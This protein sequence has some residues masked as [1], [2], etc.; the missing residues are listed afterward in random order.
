MPQILAR[1]EVLK[2]A[3][4]NLNLTSALVA[5][6]G[7]PTIR[8]NSHVGQHVPNARRP[9]T[10]M[11]RRRTKKHARD[12]PIPVRSTS[13]KLPRPTRVVHGKFCPLVNGPNNFTRAGFAVT[14]HVRIIQAYHGVVLRI[15]FRRHKVKVL[16]C[17]DFLSKLSLAGFLVKHCARHHEHIAMKTAHARN[18]PHHAVKIFSNALERFV[19]NL[20]RILH[21]PIARAVSPLH[22]DFVKHVVHYVIMCLDPMQ[23]LHAFKR[24]RVV[25]TRESTRHNVRKEA[26]VNFIDDTRAP[27][28]GSEGVAQFVRRRRFVH[29]VE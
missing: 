14:V 5:K 20:R 13:L 1:G 11:R 2:L 27:R 17:K 4:Q 19:F 18:G 10:V 29:L 22:A 6:R 12:A 8:L 16:R 15:L 7:L 23:H 3:H 9:Q 26:G 21:E 24:F 28:P 25:A